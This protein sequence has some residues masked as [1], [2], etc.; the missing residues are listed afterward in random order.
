MQ[1]GVASQFA[2]HR[3]RLT[4]TRRAISLI[5]TSMYVGA[6]VLRMDETVKALGDRP[7]SIFARLIGCAECLPLGILQVLYLIKVTRSEGSECAAGG[8]DLLSSLSLITT[9]SAPLLSSPLHVC[10][11]PPANSCM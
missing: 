10:L 1:S 7:I 2:K 8:M 5:Y 9:W 11:Q 4:K 6:C 3:K